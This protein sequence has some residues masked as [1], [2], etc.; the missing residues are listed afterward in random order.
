MKIDAKYSRPSLEDS[1]A[2]YTIYLILNVQNLLYIWM[3]VALMSTMNL[4]SISSLEYI[5]KV[6]NS[7]KHFLSSYSSV[8]GWWN[9]SRNLQKRECFLG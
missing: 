7:I 8:L 3:Y 1:Q 2:F 6:S 5:D 9:F 4:N